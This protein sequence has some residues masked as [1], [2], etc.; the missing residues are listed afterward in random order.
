M[1]SDATTRLPGDKS[2][3]CSRA[4]TSHARLDART[5]LGFND[6]HMITTE[7]ASTGALPA[8][9][10][11]RRARAWFAA[12]P[13]RTD[14]V[15]E[16]LPDSELRP[17]RIAPGFS[18]VAVSAF[19]Y[20]DTSIGPYQA[21]ALAIPCRYRGGLDLPL[22]PLFAERWLWDVGSYLPLFPVTTENARSILSAG[23]GYPTTVAN[24]DIRATADAMRCRVEGKDGPI[25]HFEIARPGTPRPT[26]GPLRTYGL[27]GDELLFTDI[28]VQGRAALG[29]VAPRASLELVARPGEGLSE[30][31]PIA[32]GLPLE[33]RWFDEYRLDLERPVARYRV[34]PKPAPPPQSS[35]ASTGRRDALARR[36]HTRRAPA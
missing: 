16:L 27:A 5:T 9:I 35:E 6:A 30:T 11:Y 8:R 2:H 12:F 25:M 4:R 10:H 1:A 14:A 31:L 20:Q 34:N 22:L 3:T 23:W 29:R 36:Q 28:E 32:N 33:V 18:V 15:L 24:V 17:I 26:S 7:V 13:C 21:A 19:D